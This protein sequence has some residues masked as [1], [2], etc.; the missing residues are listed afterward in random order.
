MVPSCRKQYCCITQNIGHWLVEVLYKYTHNEPLPALRIARLLPDGLL[1]P[2]VCMGPQ[3]LVPWINTCRYSLS[4]HNRARTVIESYLTPRIFAPPYRP[5][6]RFK[7]SKSSSA[8]PTVRPVRSLT[9]TRAAVETRDAIKSGR[10]RG[11]PGLVAEGRVF[12]MFDLL[13]LDTI[14]SK[15][16]GGRMSWALTVIRLRRCSCGWSTRASLSHRHQPAVPV[17][18]RRRCTAMAVGCRHCK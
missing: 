8:M 17:L 2:V 5:Y 16:S 18:V 15:Y 12:E 11:F 4:L 6:T 1:T 13:G 14:R 3:R 7:L 9:H 10:Y